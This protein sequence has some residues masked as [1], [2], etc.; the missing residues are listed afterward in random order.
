MTERRYFVSVAV[1]PRSP[2]YFLFVSFTMVK[3]M[4]NRS[5]EVTIM[6]MKA[7]DLSSL[8]SAMAGTG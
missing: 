5:A 4:M 1:V 7:A 8:K 6:P 3:A 2:A